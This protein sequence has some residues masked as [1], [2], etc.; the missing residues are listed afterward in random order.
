MDVCPTGIDIRNGTQLE[1][2]NCTACI[3]A[4]NRVMEKVNRPRGLIRYSSYNGI[5][6]SSRLKLSPRIAGYSVV[7]LVL[8]TVLVTLMLNRKPLA[9]TILRTPGVLY[10]ELDDGRI[11]NLYNLTIINKTFEEKPVELKLKSPKGSIDLIGGHMSVPEGSIGES[12]FF[13]KLDRDELKTTSMQI[14]IDVYSRTKLLDE[15]KTTFIGPNP[16]LK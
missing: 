10:Q 12:A 7:L 2:I 14:I 8:V 4:C 3:D 15:I 1:C 5:K 6:E 13:V 9:T 11:S 16:Y